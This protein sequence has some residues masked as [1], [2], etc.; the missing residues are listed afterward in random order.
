MSNLVNVVCEF[1]KRNIQ[2]KSILF[3][4]V[5]WFLTEFLRYY[6]TSKLL[7][8]IPIGPIRPELSN[9]FCDPGAACKS[10]STFRPNSSAH[11][12][13]LRK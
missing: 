5:A 9:P 8:Y 1:V 7:I 4:K 6:E 2:Y 10:I 3:E 12:T 13:S 11:L